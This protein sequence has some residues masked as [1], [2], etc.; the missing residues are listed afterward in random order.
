MRGAVL[1]TTT[2]TG[3]LSLTLTQCSYDKERILRPDFPMY[4]ASCRMCAVAALA[5]GP[6]FHQSGLDGSLAAPYRKALAQIFGADDKDIRRGHAMVK[7]QFE[8][9]KLA[10]A[11]LQP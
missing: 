4:R 3:S 6:A 11:G 1:S 8:A 7:Q 10:R 2:D 9:L 5:A